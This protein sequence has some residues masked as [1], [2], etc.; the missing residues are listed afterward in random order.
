M[1]KVGIVGAGTMGRT[2]SN[3]YKNVRNAVVVAVCD[4][5]EEKAL[6]LAGAHNAKVYNDFNNML[7]NEELDVIDICLPTYLHKEFAIKAINRDK[8][9][10]CEK[11]IALNVED[12]QQM[13][14][15]ARKKNVKFSV[16]HVVRFFPAY[17][18]AVQVVKAE[19]IGEPKLIRTTRNGGYPAWS[20]Q[21]WYSNYDLSGGPLLDLIIHDFDWIR[22]NFGEVERVYARCLD[23]KKL[24]HQDH[25]L[26]TLR[27][28]NGS[29]AHVEG[30]WA[31]PPGSI[32][33]T[34]FEI[35]GTKGQIEL[36]SRAS[37]PISKHIK[38]GTSS[39][40]INESPLFSDEEP[41]TAEI[42]EFINSIIEEREP[43]VSGEDAIKALKIA[44]AAIESSKTGNV[45][46]M[47]GEL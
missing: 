22:Y 7:E 30:S 35:I 41:Y 17:A 9:V 28:K 8:H 33:G 10:F 32:F 4:L 15:E 44:L 43:A 16:G 6:K 40:V 36:D 26:V 34:T 45:V 1:L 39:V 14:E 38:R 24:D 37:A 21:D 18:H 25:C 23:A 42:Q 19:R 11:P 46:L 31:Y 27:L 13:V 3:G 5:Q 12:A 47:G 29:I 20:W 2:H